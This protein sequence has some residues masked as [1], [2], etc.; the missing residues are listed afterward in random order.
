MNPS[1]V[2]IPLFQ[3]MFKD[4]TVMK[5]LIIMILQLKTVSLFQVQFIVKSTFVINKLLL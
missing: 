2:D 3:I 5:T 1:I 4:I